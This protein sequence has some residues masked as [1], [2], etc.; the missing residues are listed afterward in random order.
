MCKGRQSTDWFVGRC[1]QS[2]FGPTLGLSRRSFRILDQVRFAPTS[3]H[4]Q[5]FWVTG[6]LLNNP[7]RP[8]SAAEGNQLPIPDLAG[9]DQLAITLDFFS[10]AAADRA[11]SGYRHRLVEGIATRDHQDA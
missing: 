10:P 5:T 9:G 4:C 8:L 3:G 11:N 1:R 2:G 7:D 6:N